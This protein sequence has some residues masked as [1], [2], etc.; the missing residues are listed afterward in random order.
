MFHRVK[1]VKPLSDMILYLEFADGSVKRYDV[2][3]LMNK[4][5]VFKD[6]KQ[7]CLFNLA[8]VDTGGYGVVWNDSIDLSCDELYH[9]SVSIDQ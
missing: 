6:L 3:P 2:K 8:Q 1:S 9:N 7:D 5:D 4:W